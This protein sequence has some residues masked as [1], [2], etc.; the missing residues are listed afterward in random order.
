M[1]RIGPCKF[2][3]PLFCLPPATRLKKISSL[4]L[5]AVPAP[6]AD[7][8]ASIHHLPTEEMLPFMG[9]KAGFCTAA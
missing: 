2:P 5:I 3:Q 4:V 1:P 6:Q 8:I 7:F 9:S